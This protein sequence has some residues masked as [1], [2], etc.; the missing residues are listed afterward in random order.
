MS[1]PLEIVGDTD[2]P[3]CAGGICEIPATDEADPADQ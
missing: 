2:A 1:G 3:S